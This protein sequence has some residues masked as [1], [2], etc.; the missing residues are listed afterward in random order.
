MFGEF[1]NLGSMSVEQ[2]GQSAWYCK[3]SGDLGGFVLNREDLRSVRKE[4]VSME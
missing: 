1:R 3:Q 4:S 2:R